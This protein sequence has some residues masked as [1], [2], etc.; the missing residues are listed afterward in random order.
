MSTGS[1]LDA[2]GLFRQYGTQ[3]A[4]AESGGEYKTYGETRE[5]DVMVDLSTLTTSPLAQSYNTAFPFGSNVQIEEV[6]A[7]T[8]VGATS[9]GTPTFSVGLGTPTAGTTTNPPAI[10]TVSDTAFVNALTFATV[11]TSGG[12]VVLN[13]GSTSAG[14][15]IG[16]SAAATTS[17]LWITAKA[18]A[19]QFSAGKVRVRIRYRGLGTIAF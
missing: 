13:L 11:N 4:T 7:Y 3:K 10:T 2:D 5:V 17:T 15:Y 12:K 8:E 1:Y 19:A 14:T 6:I 9:A 18:S 16:S